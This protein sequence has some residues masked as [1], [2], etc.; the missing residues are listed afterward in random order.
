MVFWICD[1]GIGCYSTCIADILLDKIKLEEIIL[2]SG[3]SDFEIILRF[4]RKKGKKVIIVSTKKHVALEL[5][6]N[7]DKYL[8]LKKLKT[9]LERS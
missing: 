6:K 9:A 7:C 8:N 1:V 2:F 3:D 4:L 5:I